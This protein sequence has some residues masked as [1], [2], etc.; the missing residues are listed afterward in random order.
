MAHQNEPAVPVLDYHAGPALSSRDRW[1]VL[2]AAFLGWMFDGLEQGIFPL[3][4]NPALKELTGGDPAAVSKW[5]GYI[6]AAW[7]LGAALGGLVFGWLGDRIG[8]VRAMAAS[9]LVYSLFTGLGYFAGT[10]GQLWVL[11]FIAALGMGGEW[12]LGVAL[13]MECWPEK[14]RPLMAGCIGMAANF[15]ILLIA[16]VGYLFPVTPTSWRWVMLAGAVPA[17]LTFFIRLYVPESHRWQE[18]VKHGHSRPLREVFSAGLAPRTILAIAFASIALI[19]TWA[20]VQQIPVWVDKQLNPGDPRAKAMAQIACAFGAIIGTFFAPL[21]GGRLGRRP[22]FF[23]L[24]TASLALCSYLFWGFKS[25][26]A[27]FVLMVGAVG[28]VTASFYGWFP[29][30]LPELFPTRVRATGQGVSYNT[31]RILAAAAALNIGPIVALYGGDF[32]KMCGTITLVYILGM[33]FIWFAPE[34]KGKPLPE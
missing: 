16:V 22:T 18:S 8:R 23:L 13:V 20:S 34:T 27:G 12:S 32:A 31:G 5:V 1:M 19:G 17:L 26:N 10:P 33:I 29:L 15:G 9:I 14:L 30:Y 24:C 2:L 4:A 25:Y 28:C 21:I 11:R 3:I 7:L 6:T